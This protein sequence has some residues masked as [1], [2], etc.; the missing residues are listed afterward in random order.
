MIPVTLRR[1]IGIL[2]LRS[3]AANTSTHSAFLILI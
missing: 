2:T 3:L 1:D